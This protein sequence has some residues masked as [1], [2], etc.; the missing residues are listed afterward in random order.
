VIEY[1]EVELQNVEKNYEFLKNKSELF[2]KISTLSFL[3][4]MRTS[5]NESTTGLHLL[6]KEID[7][8]LDQLKRENISLKLKKVLE[9]NLTFNKIITL[10]YRNKFSDALPLI[11]NLIYDENT[12]IM[13]FFAAMKIKNIKEIEKLTS[14]QTGLSKMPNGEIL[15]QLC[16]L[17]AYNNFNQ[18]K[19]YADTF[20]GFF[21]KYFIKQQAMQPEKRFVS[22]KCFSI[23]SRAIVQHIFKSTNLLNELKDHIASITNIL[24]DNEMLHSIAE[25][26][27]K[28]N[29]VDVAH[30]IYS[31]IVERYPEDDKAKR[32]FLFYQAFKDPKKI[33]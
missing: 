8:V 7:K 28:K 25:N 10:L 1:N 22:E 19:K 12:L 13:K 30:S 14:D 29:D 5:N 23:F 26:F 17:T 3:V 32:K 9:D 4:F 20:K 31:K 16:L 18:T 2:L 15:S 27:A 33:D 6:T 21:E 11:N 24:E